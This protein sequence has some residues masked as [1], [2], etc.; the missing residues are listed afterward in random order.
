MYFIKRTLA[1]AIVM[2][3]LLSLLSC[4]ERRNSTDE[5]DYTGYIAEVSYA[6]GNMP[7]LE[8]LGEYESISASRKTT[9][10]ILWSDTDTVALTVKY[11]DETFSEAK[12]RLYSE[13]SLLTSE[14]EYLSDI[15]ASVNG[16]DI[17]IVDKEEDLMEK[18]GYYYPKC[19]LMVGANDSTQSIVYLF[20]YD[21]DLDK[22]DDLDEFIATYYSLV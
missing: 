18:Y 4:S 6:E 2:V 1:L 13:Y 21:L 14:R 8:S 22:I 10:H 17:R 7:S 19:F 16:F 20:H 12:E 11:D 15:E 3:M 9:K 5:R